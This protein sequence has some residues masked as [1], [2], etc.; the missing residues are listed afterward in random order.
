MSKWSDLSTEQRNPASHHID[1]VDTA[2][3][4]GISATVQEQQLLELQ[5]TSSRLEASRRYK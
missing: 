1:E 3:Y 2:E 4:F 5:Q